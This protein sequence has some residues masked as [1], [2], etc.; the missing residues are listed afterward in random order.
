MN[1]GI[2]AL[3]AALPLISAA[4]LVVGFK[5]PAK[6]SMPAVYLITAMIAFFVW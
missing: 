5:L 2:L 6:K 4:V 3:V 1:P